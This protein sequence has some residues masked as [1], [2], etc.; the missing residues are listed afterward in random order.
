MG[1]PQPLQVIT[2]NDLKLIESF[3]EDFLEFSRNRAKKLGDIEKKVEKRF[4]EAAERLKSMKAKV[5]FR[6][7]LESKILGFETRETYML[8][9]SLKDSRTRLYLSVA[10]PLTIEYSDKT[11]SPV[12]AYIELFKSYPGQLPGRLL[13]LLSPKNEFRGEAVI[14]I[15]MHADA[16]RADEE[17]KLLGLILASN[18]ALLGVKDNVILMCHYSRG[19]FIASSTLIL[20]PFPVIYYHSRGEWHREY[21][22]T[23]QISCIDLFPHLNLGRVSKIEYRTGPI[24]LQKDEKGLA[25]HLDETAPEEQRKQNT[26]Q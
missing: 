6:A 26:T 24:T 11:Y 20:I 17:G 7:N 5:K 3:I 21:E 8:E 23:E 13:E 2:Q 16:L 18:P 14:I 9:A 25:M 1:A 4:D 10:I 22:H 19:K 15:L 12:L